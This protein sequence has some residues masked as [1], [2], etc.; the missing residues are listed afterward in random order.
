VKRENQTFIALRLD[1]ELLAAL[2]KKRAGKRQSRSQFIRDAIFEMV[3]DYGLSRD[4]AYPA[5]RVGEAKG[6]RPRKISP[7]SKVAE[8][9]TKYPNRQTKKDHQ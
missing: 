2:D 1:P 8:A 6:G 5:D 4:L 7:L 9:E 3:K